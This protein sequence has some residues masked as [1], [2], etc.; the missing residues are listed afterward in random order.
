MSLKASGNYINRRKY[1]IEPTGHKNEW[2]GLIDHYSEIT[3]KINE[4]ENDIKNLRQK[5]LK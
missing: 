3:S 1:P 5:E 4:V 2:K